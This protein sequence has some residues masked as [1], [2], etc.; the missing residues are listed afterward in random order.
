[1]RREENRAGGW[2]RKTMRGLVKNLSL[3]QVREI[4]F[5]GRSIRTLI[6][7]IMGLNNKF[8]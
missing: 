3:L 7:S 6:L 2:K 4:D 1:M 5:F 8:S